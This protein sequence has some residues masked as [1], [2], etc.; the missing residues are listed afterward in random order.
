MAEV[1]LLDKLLECLVWEDT[2]AEVQGQVIMVEVLVAPHT[3]L[4]QI[5]ADMVV[6]EQ[7]CKGFKYLFVD[8]VFCELER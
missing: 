5:L 2:E 8:L 1:S 6:V 7:V 4:V 3:I